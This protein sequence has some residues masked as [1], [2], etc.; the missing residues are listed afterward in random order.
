MV[1]PGDCGFMNSNHGE[2]FVALVNQTV[3]GFC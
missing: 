2:E 3:S 1:E